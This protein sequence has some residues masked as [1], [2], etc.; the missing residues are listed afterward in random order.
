MVLY[1]GQQ[2]HDKIKEVELLDVAAAMISVCTVLPHID[3]KLCYKA[4]LCS[5]H[6][7]KIFLNLCHL[8]ILLKKT[9]LNPTAN[10]T[11]R[12]NTFN[13]L[14]QNKAGLCCATNTANVRVMQPTVPAMPQEKV[15]EVHTSQL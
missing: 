14:T 13:P 12:V 11:E 2:Q 7:G 6:R 9:Q 8:K 15:S 3:K 1:C 10:D 4:H 5:K